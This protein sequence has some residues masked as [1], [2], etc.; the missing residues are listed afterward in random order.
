MDASERMVLRRSV[1]HYPRTFR[2]EGVGHRGSYYFPVVCNQV[3]QEQDVS[4][5]F[6]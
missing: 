4:R 2:L 5:P 1:V 6:E 3:H